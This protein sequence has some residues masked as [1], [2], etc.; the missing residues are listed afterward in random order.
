M[1]LLYTFIMF[2][3]RNI[4]HVTL[5]VSDKDRSKKFYTETLGLD[6]KL[7]NGKYLW[8]K[9]GNEYIHVTKEV[10]SPISDTFYHFAI[11]VEGYTEYK[12]RL[13]EI[14]LLLFDLDENRNKTFITNMSNETHF[15]VNDPDGNLIEFVDSENNFF[16]Q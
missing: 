11:N 10:E 5:L 3:F 13:L 7:V 8:I 16:N 1:E 12:N 4:N 2:K 15:F 6:C 9:I 14:G